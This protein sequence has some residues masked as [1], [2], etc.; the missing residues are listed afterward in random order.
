[1]SELIFKSDAESAASAAGEAIKRIAAI[2]PF[3]VEL[4]VLIFRR[5]LMVA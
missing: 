5:K 4:E 2:A 3:I 1:V